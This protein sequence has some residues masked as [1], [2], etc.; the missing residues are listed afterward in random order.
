MAVGTTETTGASVRSAGA[1]SYVLSMVLMVVLYFSVGFI[2]SLNDI[3]IPHFKAL[4]HH[5]H[6]LAL[7]VDFCFFGAYFVM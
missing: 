4:F 1:G 6:V 2:T 5:T 7:L 3:L